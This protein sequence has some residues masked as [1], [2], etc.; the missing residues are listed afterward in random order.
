[1]GPGRGDLEGAL[2]VRLTANV[3]EV[4]V[5]GGDPLDGQNAAGTRDTLM[6]P[7]PPVNGRPTRATQDHP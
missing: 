7:L 3:D 4:E 2:R 1:M 6:W 5:L